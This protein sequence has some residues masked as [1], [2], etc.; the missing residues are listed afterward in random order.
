MLVMIHNIIAIKKDNLE[1][2]FS[3]QKEKNICDIL[4]NNLQF[5]YL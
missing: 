2:N 3:V 4:F 1:I 5:S